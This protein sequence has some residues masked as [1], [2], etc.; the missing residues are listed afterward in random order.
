MSV[1]C[2]PQELRHKARQ[3]MLLFPHIAVPCQRA[4][5]AVPMLCGT[6]PDERVLLSPRA[7]PQNRA[8]NAHGRLT[9]HGS[10]SVCIHAVSACILVPSS[11]PYATKLTPGTY[12]D[13]KR[14]TLLSGAPLV[15][16]SSRSERSR[17]TG[18]AN[19]AAGIA[20][21]RRKQAKGQVERP[22]RV[23]RPRVDSAPIAAPR[24]PHDG[25]HCRVQASGR[26]ARSG[27]VAHTSRMRSCINALGS[28]SAPLRN[29]LAV[30]SP[31]VTDKVCGA[32]HP[33]SEPRSVPRGCS[34]RYELERTLTC[35]SPQLTYGCGDGQ[36]H[37]CWTADLGVSCSAGLSIW[38]DEGKGQACAR[39]ACARRVCFNQ[40]KV[41]GAWNTVSYSCISGF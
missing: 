12:S 30:T 31:E 2:C 1:C 39:Q 6:R 7:F 17:C 32:R 25:R 23:H 33:P 11:R 16:L 26:V 36:P 18:V 4:C 13:W 19:P 24:P 20:P 5:A 35:T 15:A 22:G 37:E 38:W 10:A 3:R 27:A 28:Q 8:S 40:P 34:V 29:P 14:A 21:S 41:T 9:Q